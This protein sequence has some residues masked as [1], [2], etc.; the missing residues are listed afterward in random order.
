[1]Q[2][3]Q[4]IRHSSPPL[5]HSYRCCKLSKYSLW[6]QHDCNTRF[7]PEASCQPCECIKGTLLLE[8]PEDSKT[9]RISGKSRT[10]KVSEGTLRRVLGA[11]S[12]KYAGSCPMCG[13]KG[14]CNQ[15]W[16]QQCGGAGLARIPHRFR[17][18]VPPGQSHR[19]IHT[20]TAAEGPS[21]LCL[22]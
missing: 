17:I 8:L 21:W 5:P 11:G 9:G 22:L 10:N 4:R 18:R 3:L 12:I 19:D 1:M 7:Q 15:Q 13:G 16:C 2:S 20:R 6:P 14:I